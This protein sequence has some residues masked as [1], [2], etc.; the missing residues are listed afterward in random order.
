MSSP[1]RRC[2]RNTGAC[3]RHPPGPCRPQPRPEEDYRA[4]GLGLRGVIMMTP[5]P[6]AALLAWRAGFLRVLAGADAATGVGAL[7]RESK[8]AAA[9]GALAASLALRSRS[10]WA[11]SCLSF[12]ATRR[13]SAR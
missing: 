5:L 9:A 12:S 13:A 4:G 2:G 11:A 10:I 6:D 7:A 3:S 1:G 8:P